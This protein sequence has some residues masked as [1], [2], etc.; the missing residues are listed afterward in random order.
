MP[1]RLLKK[2][3]KVGTMDKYKV[4]IE[5]RAQKKLAKVS[6]PYYSNIKAAILDL[7]NNPRPEGYIKLRGRD[8]FRIR[9]ADYRVIYEIHDSVILVKVID[10][11][12]RRDIY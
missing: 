7:G 4:Q 9:V 10:V 3:K 12:H 11:G 5:R 6:L 2:L 8:A 1:G